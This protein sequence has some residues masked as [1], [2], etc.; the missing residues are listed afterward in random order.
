MSSLINEPGRS[1][2]SLPMSK[3]SVHCQHLHKLS[4][5]DIKHNFTTTKSVVHWDGKLMSG[6]SDNDVVKVDCFLVLM[7]SAV[8]GS[9]KL[10]RVPELLSGT[11]RDIT[12]SYQ[13]A[14]VL[15]F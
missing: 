9:T 1:S 11:G 14:L 4:A 5:Q 7:T 15:E 6:V 8:D 10:L 3:S 13:P 2:E 12:G